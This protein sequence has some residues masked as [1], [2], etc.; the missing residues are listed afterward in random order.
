MTKAL[1]ASA[2]ILVRR[3]YGDV[4]FIIAHLTDN[5]ALLNLAAVF[6]DGSPVEKAHFPAGIIKKIGRPHIHGF[7]G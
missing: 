5:I 6:A 4:K 7:F 2:P 3:T 1:E